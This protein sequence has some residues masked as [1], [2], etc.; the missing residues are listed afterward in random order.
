MSVSL[1]L[2]L[3]LSTRPSATMEQFVSHW[4]DFYEIWYLILFRKSAEK[5]QI[6]SRMTGPFREDLCAFMIISR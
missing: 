6:L 2:S 3:S 4:T 5:A 1:S